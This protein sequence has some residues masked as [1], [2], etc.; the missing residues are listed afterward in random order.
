MSPK[1]KVIPDKD[2][3]IRQLPSPENGTGMGYVISA[4]DGKSFVIDGGSEESRELLLAIIRESCGGEIA[5]WFITHPHPG[6][7]GALCSILEDFPEDIKISK[8]FHSPLSTENIEKYEPQSLPFVKRWMSV[9]K[10]F[11]GCKKVSVNSDV[12]LKVG[13][14]IVRVVA[15]GDI[16]GYT[17][18]Y[19]NNCGVVYKFEMFCT[20]VLFLGDIGRDASIAILESKEKKAMLNCDIIQIANHGRPGILSEVYYLASP[21][22][23][24]WSTPKSVGDKN[25]YTSELRSILELSDATEHYF[26]GTDGLSEIKI[27]Y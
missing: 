1:Y 9:L 14:T 27:V 11:S 13:K 8:I 17:E 26:S 10:S 4:C 24:L 5:A 16:G 22:T 2:Y 18:D 15:A 3:I 19:I 25:P 20:S 6:H 7:V 21:N 23:C 12:R